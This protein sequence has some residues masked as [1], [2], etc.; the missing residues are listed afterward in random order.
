MVQKSGVSEYWPFEAP[1]SGAPG[2]PSSMHLVKEEFS[3]R[4]RRGEVAETIKRESEILRDWLSTEHSNDPRLTAK[5]I[6]NN[7]REAFRH[8]EKPRN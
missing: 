8:Y 2:R 6:E 7:L 5:T 4:C 1:R 3:A